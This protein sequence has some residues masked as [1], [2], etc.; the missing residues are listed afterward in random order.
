M[1]QLLPHH[2]PPPF[3]F[4]DQLIFKAWHFISKVKPIVLIHAPRVWPS[5]DFTID[6]PSDAIWAWTQGP[7]APGSEILLYHWLTVLTCPGLLFPPLSHGADGGPLLTPRVMLCVLQASSHL[8]FST[9][10][11]WLLFPGPLRRPR[12]RDPVA[13]GWSQ[14]LN[15]S[16]LTL[17]VACLLSVQ[18]PRKLWRGSR[19]CVLAHSNS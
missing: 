14:N 6:R 13:S 12:S 19:S 4:P 5:P 2:Q 11:S 17:E 16:G 15:P 7:C 18:L 1:P 3:L 10:F 8:C 9:A